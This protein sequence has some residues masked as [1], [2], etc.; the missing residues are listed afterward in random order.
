MEDVF[1]QVYREI[2]A[3]WNKRRQMDTDP[4]ILRFMIRLMELMESLDP[5]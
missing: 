2:K 1:W 4:E 3:E 5:D